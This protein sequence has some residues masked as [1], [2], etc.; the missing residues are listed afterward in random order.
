VPRARR[1]RARPGPA[2][3]GRTSRIRGDG[4]AH[5]AGGSRFM[6]TRREET[7][8]S[9]YVEERLAVD[10]ADQAVQRFGGDLQPFLI[11]VGANVPLP[12]AAEL[13]C[14]VGSSD[15]R[16]SPFRR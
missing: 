12:V 6:R 16:G 9:A 2:L 5:G 15:S 8:P 14:V 7:A 3:G 13:E 1:R 10:I 4:D 11:E